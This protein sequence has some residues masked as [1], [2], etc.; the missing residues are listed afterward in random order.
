LGKIDIRQ[1]RQKLAMFEDAEGD[2][3]IPMFTFLA[4]EFSEKLRKS[5][6]RVNF[7][8]WEVD[9]LH[10]QEIDIHAFMA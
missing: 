6:V 5:N 9:D 10:T 7:K 1:P 8:Q 4:G 3:I 2:L